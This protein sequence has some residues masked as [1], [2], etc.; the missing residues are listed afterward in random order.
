MTRQVDADDTTVPVRIPIKFVVAFVTAILFG[1]MGANTA[2]FKSTPSEDRAESLRIVAEFGQQVIT[3]GEKIA[4]LDSKTESIRTDL[5]SRTASSVTKRDLEILAQDQD[6][7]HAEL[8]KADAQNQ[9]AIMALEREL[10]QLHQGAR[11]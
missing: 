7:K 5:L 9:R 6:R 10:D 2:L 8:E 4:T 11:K 1:G 3:N